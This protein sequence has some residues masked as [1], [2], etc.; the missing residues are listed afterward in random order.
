MFGIIEET[1]L[2]FSYKYLIT[3]VIVIS[4]LKILLNNK[5]ANNNDVSELEDII[6]KNANDI[7]ILKTK[8]SKLKS[9]NR[10]VLEKIQSNFCL[11]DSSLGNFT[12]KEYEKFKKEIRNDM[13]MMKNSLYIP[14]DSYS[15]SK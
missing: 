9:Y 4:F 6:I 1:L 11:I 2:N 10:D 5:D 3:I 15:D 8:I 12:Q 7:K 13:N 14:D